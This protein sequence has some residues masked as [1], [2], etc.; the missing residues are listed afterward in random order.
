LDADWRGCALIKNIKRV[1]AD[2]Y[3]FLALS[4]KISVHLRPFFLDADWRRLAQIKNIKR[5]IADNYSFPA[6][7]AQISVYQRPIVFA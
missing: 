1:V 4:A 7:S 6:L 5:V 2:N 3:S